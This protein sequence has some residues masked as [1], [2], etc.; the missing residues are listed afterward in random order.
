M[1]DLSKALGDCKWHLGYCSYD[2][3][4]TARVRSIATWQG[5]K[6]R[7]LVGVFLSYLALW[8]SNVFIKS[9]KGLPDRNPLILP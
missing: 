6:K 8:V 5:E 9:W 7:K 3:I 4:S 1:P 2:K